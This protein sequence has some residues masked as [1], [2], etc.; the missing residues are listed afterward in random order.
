MVVRQHSSRPSIIG[1]WP[2]DHG[3]NR[4]A[5]FR[6][7]RWCRF[8]TILQ[9]G[10]RWSL[11]FL[12]GAGVEHGASITQKK[13]TFEFYLTCN[14][15]LDQWKIGEIQLRGLNTRQAWFSWS[16]AAVASK[17]FWKASWTLRIFNRFAKGHFDRISNRLGKGVD[18]TQPG[19]IFAPK[20]KKSILAK[21]TEKNR[22]C[23]STSSCHEPP[24]SPPPFPLELRLLTSRI[25]KLSLGFSDPVPA[26]SILG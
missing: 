6:A 15:D 20:W 2:S 23:R 12:Q 21:W 13:K 5:S 26:R 8:W 16:S 24:P 25:S 17:C 7:H 19:A 22:K 9:N 3:F 4:S 1:R 11:F 18:G 10:F 14:S